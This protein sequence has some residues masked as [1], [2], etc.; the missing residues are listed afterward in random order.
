MLVGAVGLCAPLAHGLAA[1]AGAGQGQAAAHGQVGAGLQ[2]VQQGLQQ[3]GVSVGCFDK[4]LRLAALERQ[5]LQCADALGAFVGVLRQVAHKGKVLPVEPAGRQ[6][7]QQRHR[8]HQR[9]HL[10][11]QCVRCTHHR[12]AGVGHG[13]HAR[14]ADQAHVVPG[15]GGG[16]QGAGV[17]RRRAFVAVVAFFVHFTRQFGDVL[18]LQG[19]RQRVQRVDAL[20]VGARAL[21]VLAHPVGDAGGRGQRGVGQGVAQGCLWLAA[22][23]QRCG[24]QVQTAGG[25]GGRVHGSVRPAARSMRQVRI[26]GRPTRAVGSSLRMASSRLMPRP[27]LLALPAQS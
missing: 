27:S 17:K 22:K 6:R 13:G 23:V 10:Q 8:P 9:Y 20:E 1:R 2:G 21:G 26:K 12:A 3:G 5:G 15:Q 24:H 4:Q 11:P 19:Q 7:Q 25:G 14:F 18:F 16:E